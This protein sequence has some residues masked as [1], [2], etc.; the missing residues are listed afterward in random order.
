MPVAIDFHNKKKTKTMCAINYLVSNIPQNIS[1]LIQQKK[2]THKG[3][4]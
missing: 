2:E 3:L 1:F 4:E